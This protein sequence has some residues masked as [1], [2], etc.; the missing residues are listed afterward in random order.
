MSDA[1]TKDFEARLERVRRKAT[2]WKTFTE[3]R[4]GDEVAP[5]VVVRDKA[6]AIGRGGAYQYGEAEK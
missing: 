3:L 1:Y 5:G 6:A 4:P 2:N